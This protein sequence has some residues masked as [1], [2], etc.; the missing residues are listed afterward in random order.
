MKLLLDMNLSPVWV[1]ALEEQ[2]YEAIHWSQVGDPG[3]PDAEL[4]EWAL[5][6]GYIVFTHD[7]DFTRLLALTDAEGPSVVQ[8]RSQSVLPDDVGPLLFAALR[9][10]GELLEQGALVVIDAATSRARILPIK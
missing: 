6:E 8:L 3:A 5:G 1:K 9:Q 7:L 10:H 2:G 4:L